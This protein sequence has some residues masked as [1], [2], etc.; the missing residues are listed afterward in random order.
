M[1]RHPAPLLAALALALPLT[2]T[3][4]ACASTARAGG[5]SSTGM[6]A[7][8]DQ[9]V[10]ARVKTVLLNDPQ[11]S[12]TRI[13]VATANG[14]VTISGTVKSKAEEQRAIQLT[15]QVAGVKDVRSTL[16]IPQL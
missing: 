3:S 15:R 9:I 2:L 7:T 16:T 1:T 6:N 8:D 4:I 14:V 12:A 5:S 13:D 10:T 11:I